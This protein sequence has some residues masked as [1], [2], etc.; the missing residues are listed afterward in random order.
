MVKLTLIETAL[1]LAAI[2]AIAQSPAQPADSPKEVVEQFCRM[3][4]Q[5]GQLNSKDWN[6]LAA[7]STVHELWH[8]PSAIF[9]IRNYEVG[10]P[11]ELPNHPNGV[12]VH[13]DYFSWGSIDQDLYFTLRQGPVL[14]QPMKVTEGVNLTLA[15]DFKDDGASPEA[16]KIKKPVRWRMDEFPLPH[17]NV[18]TAIRFV[19]EMRSKSDDPLVKYKADRTLANLKGILAGTLVAMQSTSSPKESPE[20]VL[21]RFCKLE[22]AGKGLTPDGRRELAGFFVET[23]RSQWDKILVVDGYRLEDSLI[24]GDRAALGIGYGPVGL[25]DS[26]L[27]ISEE[28]LDKVPGL[29]CCMDEFNY[30]LLLLDRHWETALDG[31]S[32]NEIAGP[33]AWRIENYPPLAWI[34]VRTAI[35]YV[36]EMR[37][38]STDAATK[39]NADETLAKLRMPRESP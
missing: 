17:V 18:E 13:V 8:P 20:Q 16:N 12:A 34:S 22:T 39:K 23:P 3:D 25:L 9:V 28:G 33:L 27:R 36:T 4:E 24:E 30:S 5:G 26:S 21:L 32:M 35:R 15:E 7:F 14:G 2:P 19:T 31:R 11:R 38:K 1:C 10:D 37:D 29:G 6:E